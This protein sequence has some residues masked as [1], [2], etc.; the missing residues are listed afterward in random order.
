M[1]VCLFVF[2]H[3]VILYSSKCTGLNL[4]IDL[5]ILNYII[6]HSVTIN[7]GSVPM[8]SEF[9]W[10]AGIASMETFQGEKGW[11]HKVFLISHHSN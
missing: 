1:F 11:E 3:L 2:I 4:H 10:S 5:L 7:T 8:V 6:S 9:F